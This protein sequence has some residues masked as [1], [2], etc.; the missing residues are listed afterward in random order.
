MIGNGDCSQFLALPSYSENF[1]NVV[2][3]AMA[4]GCPV[5]VTPEVGMASVVRDAGCGVVAPGNAENFGLEMNRL[6]NDHGRRQN[7]GKAG[8]R[9]AKEKYS[10]NVIGQQM[11]K[12]YIDIVG[13]PR[14]LR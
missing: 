8:R 9:V 12:V 6:L 10:W 2:L 13:E 3:E 14:S 5:I 7:M 11:L 1:G 4:A